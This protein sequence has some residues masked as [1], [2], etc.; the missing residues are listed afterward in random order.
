MKRLD[1]NTYGVV[2][3][4]HQEMVETDGGGLLLFLVVVAVV[5]LVASS[6]SYD[7]SVTINNNSA[8][9]SAKQ[10]NVTVD[11]NAS[12]VPQK[13]NRHPKV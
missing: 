2:E 7:N 3:M 4:N 1:L 6:C 8:T 5:G 12:V 11:A 13:S 10:T 9:D